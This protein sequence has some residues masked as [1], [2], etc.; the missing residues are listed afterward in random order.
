MHAPLGASID[1]W[2]IA[3]KKIVITDPLGQAHELQ[4]DIVFEYKVTS[5]HEPTLP[6]YKRASTKSGPDDVLTLGDLL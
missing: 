1:D 2:A 4:G 6:L 5:I 3:E